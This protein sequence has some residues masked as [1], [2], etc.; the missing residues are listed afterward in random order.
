MSCLNENSTNL[1][2]LGGIFLPIA[3]FHKNWKQ[4]KFYFNN[5]INNPKP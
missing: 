4:I 5:L 2:I 3:W 1:A